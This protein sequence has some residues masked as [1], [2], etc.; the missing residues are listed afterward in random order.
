M[1]NH[2]VEPFKSSGFV[3]FWRK[4]D[5]LEEAIIGNMYNLGMP[6]CVAQTGGCHIGVALQV[7]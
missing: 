7:S 5:E 6:S 3:P 1:F 2:K 4:H